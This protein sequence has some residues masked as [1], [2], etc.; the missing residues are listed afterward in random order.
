MVCEGKAYFAGRLYVITR[1]GPIGG[2]TASQ[3]ETVRLVPVK[4]PSQRVYLLTAAHSA[5]RVN[6]N[7]QQAPTSQRCGQLSK[8]AGQGSPRRQ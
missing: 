2:N 4:R 8:F 6:P 7:L 3:E 5:T 1:T